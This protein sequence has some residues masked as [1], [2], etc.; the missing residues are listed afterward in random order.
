[1]QIKKDSVVELDGKEKYIVV[2]I[3]EYEGIE[4]AILFTSKDDKF[5]TVVCTES[6]EGKKV[7]LEEVSNPVLVNKVI[8]LFKKEFEKKI[9]QLKNAL[10]NKDDKN[11]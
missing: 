9:D 2:D 4:Y 10:N 1:M 11:D 3:I 7:F 6:I 8:N 5:V